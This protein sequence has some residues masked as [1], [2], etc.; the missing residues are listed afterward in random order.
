MTEDHARAFAIEAH[1]SIGQKR[2]YTGEPYWHHPRNVVEIL[3]S[4]RQPEEVLCGGWLHDVCEDT[5]VTLGQIKAAFG[6]RIANLVA[7]LTDVSKPE[8]GNRE[9]RKE[10][11][12]NHIAQAPPEAKTIK[13]ADLIDNSRSILERD[14][15][16]AKVYIP[17]K[18]LLLGVLK[19]GDATLWNMA[20]DI[21]TAAHVD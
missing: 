15:G 3:R 18:R 9:R 2:K 7:W 21:V 1:E 20:N 12:R 16:F 11:D 19:E 13:L 17:E 14:P 8:D 6:F 4:V 10:I 5:P